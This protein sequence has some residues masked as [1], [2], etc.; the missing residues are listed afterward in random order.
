M[1]KAAPEVYE[2]V[3]AGIIDGFVFPQ[4][5][6]NSLKLIPLFTHFTDFPGGLYNVSFSTIMNLGKWDQISKADQAA[7]ENL[8][9]EKLARLSGK[10]WDEADAKG[11][12]AMKQAGIKISTA[13]PTLVADI[14]RK[15]EHLEVEWAKAAKA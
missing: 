9:G 13:S 4:E 14:K 10:A 15:T 1:F 7:M 3:S 6:P 2:L 5:T 8:F 12:A 11:V